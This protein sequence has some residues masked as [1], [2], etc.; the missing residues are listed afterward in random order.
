MSILDN[1]LGRKKDIQANTTETIAGGVTNRTALGA[2]LGYQYSGDRNIY[3]ALGYPTE[4]LFKDY[5]AKYLR[6][7]I[8]KAVINRPIEATWRGEVIVKD[9]DDTKE[10]LQNAW[11]TLYYELNLKQ[12]FIRLDKLASI[13]RFGILLLGFSDTKTIF[14]WEK[15]VKKGQGLKLLY[16]TPFSESGILINTYEQDPTNKRYGLPLTY[17]INVIINEKES[18]TRIV[19]WTRVIHVTG[20]ILDNE[21]YG[22]PILESIYNRLLDL[23]KLVGAGAETFWR[24]ARPGFTGKVNEDY[25]V[26]NGTDLKDALDAQMLEY[27]HNL[28]RFFIAEGVDIQAL[29]QQ[30]ADP[31]GNVDVQIQMI[32]AVTGIPKRILIGSERGELSSNQDK[33]SWIELITTRREEYAQIQILYPF[34]DR[35]MEYGILPLDKE[36]MADWSSLYEVKELDKVIVGKTRTEALNTYVTNP[37]ASELMPP[38]MFYKHLLGLTEEQIEE[39]DSFIAGGIDNIDLE[40]EVIPA[41]PIISNPEETEEETEIEE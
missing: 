12:K 20:E 21:V 5:L 32:S 35:M 18:I 40:E 30:L 34:V 15:P 36:Y 22:V 41:E 6:M 17:S 25:K 2:Y 7:D 16:V 39:I 13:G 29:Q 26:P 33:D 38:E 3:T 28:R 27:E 37:M 1:I 4:I 14:D 11:E 9:V 31:S 24:G 8:A 10:T 19:H 23:E